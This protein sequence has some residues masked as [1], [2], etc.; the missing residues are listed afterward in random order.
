MYMYPNQ[1]CF[2][3]VVDI[4]IIIIIIIIHTQWVPGILSLGVKRPVREA[5]HWPPSSV[6]VNN[7]WS[8]TSTPPIPLHGVVLS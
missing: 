6:E 3:I 7:S 4:I 5:D 2:V 8:Y 1:S